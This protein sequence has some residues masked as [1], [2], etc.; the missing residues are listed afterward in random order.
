[1]IPDHS[2]GSLFDV[3]II[4]EDKVR[5]RRSRPGRSPEIDYIISVENSGPRTI[6]K[7]ILVE[8]KISVVGQLEQI[9]AYAAKVGTCQKF[10]GKVLVSVLIDPEPYCLSF[11][12]YMNEQQ[13][14]NNGEFPKLPI[15][16]I[17]NFFC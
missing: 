11:P 15:Q 6:I 2:S 9:A 12:A 4:P 16:V 17:L 14:S 1:M 8:V 10:A 7:F 5:L 3:Q 13:Q